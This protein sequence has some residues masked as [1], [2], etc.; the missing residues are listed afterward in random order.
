MAIETDFVG[1]VEVVGED[2]FGGG[3]GLGQGA[4]KGFAIRKMD[5]QIHEAD[6]RGDFRRRDEAGEDEV[7]F[8]AQFPDAPGEGFAE[9][10]VADEEKFHT[11]IL[12]DDCGREREEVG[13]AFE[14]KEAG[15]FADDEVVRRE[16][17]A[18]A[19]GGGVFGGG[20]RSKVEAA[21]DASV[22]FRLADASGE[23]A[24]G[25]GVGGGE[26]VGGDFPGMAFGG[27]EGEVGERVLEFAE[28]GAVDVVDDERHSSAV[29]GETAKKTSFAAV[30]VDEVGAAVVENLFEL[31]Q[32]AEIFERMDGADE[33]RDFSETVLD[34][35]DE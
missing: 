24:A 33:V 6:V 25:H 11:R 5:E 1:A 29:G 21:E 34:F 15:D 31:A 16:A 8:Q 7:F 10:A 28:G 19:E 23:V 2:G 30:G 9:N 14:R 27:A 26:E 12:A 17:V 3:E 20:V 13:V 4:G 18:G 35:C 32:G 22:V